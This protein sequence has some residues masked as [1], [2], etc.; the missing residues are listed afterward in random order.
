MV[1]RKI[2]FVFDSTKDNG[3]EFQLANGHIS[4]TNIL[5]ERENIAA[6]I[7]AQGKIEFYSNGEFVEVRNLPEV[8]SGKGV[9]DAVICTVNGEL[10]KFEFP[11][12]EWIDTYPN[13]DGEHDRWVTR[14]IGCETVEFKK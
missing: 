1:E 10:I 2:D 4:E 7:Y 8:D 9:Y 13:C 6:V 5:F 11:V 12:Y 3:K 14:K